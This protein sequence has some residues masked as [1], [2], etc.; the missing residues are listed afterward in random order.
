MKCV[1]DVRRTFKKFKENYLYL[2]EKEF[3]L[4][5]FTVFLGFTNYDFLSLVYFYGSWTLNS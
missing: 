5:L 3:F 1:V 4:T 2:K